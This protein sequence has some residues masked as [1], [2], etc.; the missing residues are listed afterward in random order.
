MALA[1]GVVLAFLGCSSMVRRS[2]V[3]VDA[4]YVLGQIEDNVDRLRDFEGQAE[5]Y[6]RRQGV[7][8]RASML[9]LFKQPDLLNI[10][11]YGLLGVRLLEMSIR[12]EGLTLY[13][14]TVDRF[15]V[16]PVEGGLLQAMTGFDLHFEELRDALL[17]TL[18]VGREDLEHVAA[19]ERGK[20]TYRIV[21]KKADRIHRLVVDDGQWTVLEDELFNTNGDLIGR[22]TMRRFG[23]F[24]GVSL[25]RSIEL[26]RGE[27]RIQIEFTSQRV[28]LGLSDTRFE[29]RRPQSGGEG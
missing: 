11:V 28:N 10:E 15:I 21:M 19:F 25:P 29:I 26:T 7:Y 9:V 20:G 16:E 8:Q 3:E 23:R 14:P 13:A 1:L 18:H 17:G 2:P 4:G 6:V 24:N 12:E 27:D 22:R 5:V